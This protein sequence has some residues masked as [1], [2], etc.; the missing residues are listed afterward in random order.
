MDRITRRDEIEAKR[1]AALVPE[2]DKRMRVY[3]EVM[4]V[5]K[6]QGQFLQTRILVKHESGWKVW[7]SCP[8]SISEV[9][10]GDVVEFTAKVKRSDQDPKFGFFSRPTKGRILTI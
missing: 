7:G 2:E 4:T 10:R 5:R 3:G 9:K 6:D 1:K 8:S